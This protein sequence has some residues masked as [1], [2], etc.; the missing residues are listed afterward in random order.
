MT[1]L[2]KILNKM[3]T[4]SSSGDE[5][6]WRLLSWNVTG[7]SEARVE[8]LSELPFDVAALQETHLSGFQLGQ[9]RLSA[10]R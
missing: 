6:C 7:L 4:S 10:R 9:R 5:E 2:G 3:T 1:M 8:R